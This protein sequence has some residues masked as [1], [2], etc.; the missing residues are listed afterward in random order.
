LFFPASFILFWFP[1]YINRAAGWNLWTF[2]A[3]Y[4]LILAR[5]AALSRAAIPLAM[6]AATI[7]MAGSMANFPLLFAAVVKYNIPENSSNCLDGLV[8]PRETCALFRERAEYIKSA[9]TERIV[10]LTHYPML[11]M[12][13]SGDPGK[14]L[15]IDFIN[16]VITRR[17]FDDL[18]ASLRRMSPAAILVDSPSEPRLKIPEEMMRLTAEITNALAV[19]YC[20]SAEVAGWR[21]LRRC[22][23]Q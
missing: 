3:A 2:M 7:T 6:F 17:E 4:C 14:L 22:V 23:T 13:M 11:T 5:T 18:V 12:R 19:E 10:W 15:K 8:A 21:V 9:S 1:Y 16:L 20:P